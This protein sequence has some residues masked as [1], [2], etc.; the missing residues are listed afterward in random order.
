MAIHSIKWHVA[1]MSTMEYENRITK[2]E[3]NTMLHKRKI[4]MRDEPCRPAEADYAWETSKENVM[5]LKRGRNISDLNRALRMHDSFQA[6]TSLDAEAHEMEQRV[7]LYEGD[8]PISVWVQFVR[9]I[10]KNRPEDTRKKFA[11]LEKCTR[12]LKDHIEYK[13]DLRYIRLWIQ[14][15]GSF[16]WL[17]EPD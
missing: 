9:W 13:N 1:K 4:A 3:N 16:N 12:Q 8:D 15:V 2:V 6:M 11:V 7:Q 14:Y 17:Q 5:P 10:E